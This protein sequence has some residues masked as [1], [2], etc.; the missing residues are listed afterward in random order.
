VPSTLANLARLRDEARAALVGRSFPRV[1]YHA[2]LRSKHVQVE[3]D[4]RVVA[5]LDFGSAESFDLPYFDLLHFLAHE[6]KQ[7]ER[8]T[9]AQAWQLVCDP[10]RLRDW[11]RD[12]LD[13][14]AQR[15]ALDDD[16]RRTLERIYPVLVAAMAETHWDYSR[17]RW[18]HRQFGL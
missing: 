16:Y 10:A 5:L 2:D 7:A 14:Y 1:I 12:A 8:L 13:D 17:P 9:A 15:L 11:E 3:R 4:G 6:R 18:L